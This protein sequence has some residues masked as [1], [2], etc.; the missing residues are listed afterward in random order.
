MVANGNT[1]SSALLSSEW[2]EIPF[3]IPEEALVPGENVVCLRFATATPGEVDGVE[4]K[5]AA[6]VERIQLP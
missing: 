4:G 6:L 1:L 3:V 2:T 5:V